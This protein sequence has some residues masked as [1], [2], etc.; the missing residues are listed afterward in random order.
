MARRSVSGTIAAVFYTLLAI[1]GLIG[2]FHAPLLFL[3]FLL[4]GA[5]ALYLWRGGSFILFFF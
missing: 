2:G 1:G 4:F 5:Y 3:A